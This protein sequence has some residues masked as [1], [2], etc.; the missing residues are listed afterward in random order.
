MVGH[1]LIIDCKRVLRVRREHKS[2]EEKYNRFKE[3]C[4]HDAYAMTRG[5]ELRQRMMQL[6][7]VCR[8]QLAYGVPTPTPCLLFSTLLLSS[9]LASGFHVIATCCSVLC[10]ERFV[11]PRVFP[12]HTHSS[13][14]K[15]D[16]MYVCVCVVWS[17]LMLTDEI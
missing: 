15:H 16:I 17:F 5:E 13:V 4:S 3:K 6:D 2:S 1:G 8:E 9:L 7:L 10:C 11:Y 12:A 14:Q